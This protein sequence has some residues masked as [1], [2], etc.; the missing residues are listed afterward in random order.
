M[1][2]SHVSNMYIC[3]YINGVF[4]NRWDLVF[5]FISVLY[6]KIKTTILTQRIKKTKNFTILLKP[7]SVHTAI[8]T[9]AKCYPNSSVV[10]EPELSLIESFISAYHFQY[11]W[12]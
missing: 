1:H 5:G 10:V 12:I 2:N 8:A 3:M 4:N 7:P 6:I 11:P 9:K